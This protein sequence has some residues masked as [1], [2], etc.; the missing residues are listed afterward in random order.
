EPRLQSQGRLFLNSS[1]ITRQPTRSDIEV[2]TIP[3][4]DIAV[5]VGEKRTANM[6]MLGAYISSL[7]VVSKQNLLE[8]LKEFFAKKTQF[9]Q[10]N[11]TAFERGFTYSKH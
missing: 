6:V 2:I 9:L 5:E 7:N 1:L 3:A 8:G 10:V 11:T 4:N